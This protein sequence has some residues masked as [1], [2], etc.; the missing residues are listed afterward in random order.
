MDGDRVES[1]V[2]GQSFLMAVSERM[3]A[4]DAG[5]YQAGQGTPRPWKVP[6]WVDVW[7]PPLVMTSIG[8]CA[9]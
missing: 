4:I 5:L 1:I 8:C 2:T 7:E 6:M 9:G 3:L